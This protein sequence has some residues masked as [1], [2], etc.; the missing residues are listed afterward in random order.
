MPLLN[1]CS[2]GR[3]VSPDPQPISTSQSKARFALSSRSLTPIEE[4]QNTKTIY[5]TSSSASEDNGPQIS[6]V[7]SGHDQ[8]PLHGTEDSINRRHSS[9][10]LY[11][12]A[13]KVR[14]RISRDSGT[15]KRSC[16][17]HLTATSARELLEIHDAEDGIYRRHSS[18]QLHGVAGKIRRRLS[19]DSGI[20]KR[21]SKRVLRNSLSFE[22]T[23]RRAE[24]KR[25]LHQRVKVRPLGNTFLFGCE[26]WGASP[27][28]G[29]YAPHLLP[30]IT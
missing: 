22:G 17:E 25:A 16:R 8:L 15:S 30:R 18:R 14:K 10:K 19:R 7:T 26:I 11:D 20:S 29:A 4:P 27:I 23:E 5:K 9:R 21:S 12:V 6:S 2:C 24:L 1:Y 3:T 13:G 28:L